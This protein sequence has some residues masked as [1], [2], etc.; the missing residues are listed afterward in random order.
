[1]KTAKIFIVLTFLLAFAVCVSAQRTQ[2]IDSLQELDYLAKGKVKD[3]KFTV[4]TNEDVE[5]VF[6]EN[7]EKSCIYENDWDIYFKYFDEKWIDKTFVG[8]KVSIYKP[9]PEFI[10][11]LGSIVIQPKIQILLSE[12]ALF[13]DEFECRNNTFIRGEKIRISSRTCVKNKDTTYIF[14]NE[15]TADGKISK[16][17]LILVQFT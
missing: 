8:N 1:M 16:G 13:P 4:S 3:L 6:G 14:S 15:T 17:Q 7:C 11:K 10:G 5:K 9:K 2:T 12:N